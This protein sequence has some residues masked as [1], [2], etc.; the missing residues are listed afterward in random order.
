MALQNIPD[1]N[2]FLNRS[3]TE[4]A[5]TQ[6]KCPYCGRNHKIPYQKILLVPVWSVRYLNYAS[7][8][9]A[10]RPKK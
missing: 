3:A 5:N 7:M 6:I 8:P 9:W 1:V 4:L 2:D 10:A